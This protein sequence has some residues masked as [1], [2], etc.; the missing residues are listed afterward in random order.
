MSKVSLQERY[1]K[2]TKA[3]K[4]NLN[5]EELFLVP[6]LV[7]EARPQIQRPCEQFLLHFLRRTAAQGLHA[8][9]EE[10]QAGRL[11]QAGPDRRRVAES[12]EIL[13]RRARR[14]VHAQ[15]AAE[16]V[17]RVQQ[18]VPA[19]RAGDRER[20]VRSGR[21]G[22]VP[23]AGRQHARV[24]G[25]G[26]GHAGG[27]GA[28]RGAAGHGAGRA[29]PHRGAVHVEGKVP[30]EAARQD[31]AGERGAGR[32]G[33]GAG[34]KGQEAQSRRVWLRRGARARRRAVARVRGERRVQKDAAAR[35]LGRS[36][37]DAGTGAR[38]VPRAAAVCRAVHGGAQEVCAA[39]D[40]VQHPVRRGDVEVE[41]GAI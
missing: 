30:A 19:A 20:G 25:H 21:L 35:R 8:V 24:R 6:F 11:L 37:R 10:V 18:G 23:R 28:A 38:G 39:P 26:R 27:A 13:Q 17:Q 31:P 29:A 4:Y 33:A 3:A 1:N 40:V 7:H 32:D 5:S 16:E 14:R 2:F 36:G 12:V 9:E 22:R 15:R 41:R 34:E